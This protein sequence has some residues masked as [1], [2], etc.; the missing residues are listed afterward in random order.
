MPFGGMANAFA[1]YVYVSV[2]GKLWTNQYMERFVCNFMEHAHVHRC[3]E[4]AQHNMEGTISYYVYGPRLGY[5][6]KETQLNGQSD[7][8]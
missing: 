3:M 8:K 6:Q 1:W 4:T 5:I 2:S 7:W